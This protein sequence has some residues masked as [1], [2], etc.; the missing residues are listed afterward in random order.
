MNIGSLKLNNKALLKYYYLEILKLDD[1][2][3]AEIEATDKTIDYLYD[4]SFSTVEILSE[5]TRQ[6]NRSVNQTNLT[7]N[8]WKNSLIKRNAYYLHHELRISSP[9]PVY[10]FENDC[11]KT[12]PFYLE[13]KIRYTIDD[14]LN[15]FYS[16]MNSLSLQLIDKKTDKKTVIFLMNKYD[17]IDYIEPLDIILYTIDKK[18]EE[19]PNCYKLIDTTN[20][21]RKHIE[22][23]QNTMMELEFKDLRKIVA[24]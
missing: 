18:F 3:D 17:N 20:G 9:S 13:M 11:I 21:A 23:L 5:L 22:N 12:Y 15:Y 2:Q 4:C 1:I 16:K 6:N 19:D 7:N 14:V 10:D 24:R 8:L